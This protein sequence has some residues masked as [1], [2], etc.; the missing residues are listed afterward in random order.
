[1]YWKSDIS[2]MANL[3]YEFKSALTK[4]FLFK[5]KV[6][7]YLYGVDTP[8]DS[9]L[10]HRKCHLGIWIKDFGFPMYGHIPEMQE[11]GKVHEAIHDYAISLIKLKQAGKDEAAING[12]GRLEELADQ[13]I[14]LMHTIQEKSEP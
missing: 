1:M 13:I 8:L 12:I 5:S 11:L 6:K 4:H 7:S 14:R 3:N 10:D 9:I 2:A